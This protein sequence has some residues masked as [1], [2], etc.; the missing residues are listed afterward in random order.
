M[1]KGSFG[2]LH[3][4]AAHLHDLVVFCS[5]AW[6]NQ[7]AGGVG[8]KYELRVELSLGFV[9]LLE[10]F[11]A[12]CLELGYL[13][14]HL[15]RALLVAL[16]HKGSDLGGESFLLGQYS[17]ALCLQRTSER[18]EFKNPVNNGF[19]IEILDSQFFDDGLGVVSKCFECQH[20]FRILS[21]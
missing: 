5:L 19:G 21:F 12:L 10:Q 15:L 1:R 14:F 13:L 4:R 16:L 8:Q 3:F 2:K 11:P 18:V 20:I 7:S 17:V 9:H 6:F